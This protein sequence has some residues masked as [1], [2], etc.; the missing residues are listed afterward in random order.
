MSARQ[1]YPPMLITGGL[2]DPR[3]TYWEP[4]KWNARLRAMR[5]DG[6]LQLLKINMG[7]G[8]GGQSGRWTRLREVA[9]AYA[10]ILTQKGGGGAAV[11][12]ALAAIAAASLAAP[13]AA[14]PRRRRRRARS[15]CA[16]ARDGERWTAEFRFRRASAGL[17]VR[18]APPLTRGRASSPWRPRSWTVETPGVRLERRGRYDVLVAA[19]GGPVPARVRVRF[20]PFAGDLIADYDPALVFTDGSVA[21][22]SEQFDA[23]PLASAA[24]AGRLPVDLDR[25]RRSAGPH[26]GH[27]PRRGGPV[28][29]CRP[30]RRVGVTLDE[31]DGTYVLFGPAEPIVTDDDRRDHRSA[32]A[33]MAP[34][35]RSPARRRTSSPATP[36][37]SAPRRGAK[38]TI[39]VS[40]AGPTP[41]RHQ[42]G[43]QHLAGPDRHDLSKATACS[44]KMTRRAPSA[45]GSSPMK[46]RI[47]GSARRSA[48]NIARDAWITEGGADLLA[49]R[50]VA[51]VDPALRSGAP[52]CRRA[53]ARLR[54]AERRPRRRRRRASATSIALIMPAARSS[55]W[56]P[57]RRRGGPS[58]HFVRAADR[59]Q[60]RRRRSSPAPNGWP[61]STGVSGD[62][63]AEPRHRAACST[64][65]AADPKAAIA[66]LFTRAGV[67]LHAAGRTACRGCSDAVREED[68]RQAATTSTSSATSTMPPG[69]AGSRTWRPRT[70]TR[71]RRRSHVDAYIWVVIRHEIDYLRAVGPGE[72][73][74]GRTW[75]GEP[76][77]GARFD[78]HVEFVGEDGKA[79]VRARTTWAILDKATRPAAARAARGGGAV[80]GLRGA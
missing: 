46:R 27:L 33:G 38:P 17:G 36:P 65:G 79:R 30:P 71:S 9:E 57:K 31:G 77:K 22:Y 76:P 47:S 54:A 67:A 24:A 4:A 16:V 34:A 78:R 52:S 63:L 48:T 73:V 21:L 19:D 75:V 29:P 51:A 32:A 45:S 43:R 25:R 70:G 64:S 58:S 40:W 59:R 6:N 50:T 26:P 5:T 10:F 37:R 74:T 39:M 41:R 18:R 56:S 66:S 12:R 42:H 68:H 1:A 44:R 8:H 60:P 53:I 7:A 13:R 23:F 11:R 2:N 3:V 80:P 15:R 72:T 62:P 14:A 28:L 55:P 35:T 69:C 20:T 49:V 61:R